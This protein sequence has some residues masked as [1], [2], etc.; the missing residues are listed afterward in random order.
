M[1]LFISVLLVLFC[2]MVHSQECRLEEID[3]DD[4]HIMEEKINSLLS[5]DNGYKVISIS[6]SKF[7]LYVLVCK[8]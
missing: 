6:S 8:D 3:R 2:N 1:K 4:H 7:W 5:S